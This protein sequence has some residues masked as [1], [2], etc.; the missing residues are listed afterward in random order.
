MKPVEHAKFSATKYGGKW[1]DYIAIHDFFDQTKSNMPDIR[2]R[3]VLHNSFGIFLCEQQF[4]TVIT[5][6]EGKEIATR[7][8][9]EDHVLEDLGQI[10]TLEDWLHHIPIEE[11]Q[12]LNIRETKPA[13]QTVSEFDPALVKPYLDGLDLVPT[14][15]S[16][17]AQNP[18]VTPEIF[19]PPHGTR[20]PRRG[21]DNMTTRVFD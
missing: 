3:A 14:K 16:E 13:H 6:S 8:I 9:G 11:A 4:G 20:R 7:S 5:N 15:P 1:Q 19:K 10:P 2:H 18:I 12:A 17:E 21:G